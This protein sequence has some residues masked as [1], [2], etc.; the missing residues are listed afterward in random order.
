MIDVLYL[1]RLD[2]TNYNFAT[3]II[4]ILDFKINTVN[5]FIDKF[6]NVETL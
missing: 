4:T 2:Y 1:K 5:R 6:Q 3:R